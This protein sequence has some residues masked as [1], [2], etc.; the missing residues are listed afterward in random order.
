MLL[1]PDLTG[2]RSTVVESGVVIHVFILMLNVP[3]T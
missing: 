1:S 3:L 2:Y